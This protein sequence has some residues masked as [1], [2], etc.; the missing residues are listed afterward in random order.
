MLSDFLSYDAETGLITW[1]V[2]RGRVKAGAVAGYHHKGDNYFYIKIRPNRYPAHRI[3]WYLYYGRW[4]ENV[5][6][7][8]NG[9]GSDNRLCN[10]REATMSQNSHNMRLNRNNTSGFKGVSYDKL[11]RKWM[12][13]ARLDGKFIN[14]GRYHTPEEA[15]E[16]ARAGRERLHREFHNHGSASIK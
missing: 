8:I 16:A 3:A 14:L 1:K 12:A 7:H 2:N 5:I 6:D 9:D 10:L 13:H 4:P 11:N 15:D